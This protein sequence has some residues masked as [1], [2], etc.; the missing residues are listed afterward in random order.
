[1]SFYLDVLKRFVRNKYRGKLSLQSRFEMA[2][3]PYLHLCEESNDTG[4]VQLQF[5]L[6]TVHNEEAKAVGRVDPL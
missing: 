6:Q 2:K 1:M 4:F 3:K 5:G